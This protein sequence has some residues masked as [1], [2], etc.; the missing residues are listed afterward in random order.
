MIRRILLVLTALGALYWSLTRDVTDSIPLPTVAAPVSAPAQTAQQGS[1]VL[2]R[3]FQNQQ[4]NV[5]IQAAGT[6]EKIL[7]DDNNGSR[8]QRFIVRVSPDQ[9]VL[10]AH[11]IDLAKRISSLKEGDRVEFYGEYEWN[12]K[13]GVVHWTHHDPAKRHV[14]GW[15]KHNG[16]MYQ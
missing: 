5:Q 4:S 1:D 3:A 10:I 8:H 9:T 14:G 15:I 7:A 13:G 6:V 16:N 11:N 12:N 2:S